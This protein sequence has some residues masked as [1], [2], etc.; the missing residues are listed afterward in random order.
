[1]SRGKGG[2]ALDGM[3]MLFYHHKGTKEYKDIQGQIFVFLCG[4]KILQNRHCPRLQ[5]NTN[6]DASTSAERL[7]RLRQ[8]VLV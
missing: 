4:K 6:P 7:V 5:D 2:Y 3:E 8:S 1:M